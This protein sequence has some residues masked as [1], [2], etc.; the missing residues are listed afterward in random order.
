MGIKKSVI[1]LACGLLS[2]GLLSAQKFGHIDVQKLL[3]VMPEKKNADLEYQKSAQSFQK[4]FD[5]MQT[6]LQGKLAEYQKNASTYSASLRGIKEKE[7]ADMQQRIQTYGATAQQELAKKQQDL[8]SPILDKIKNAIKMVGKEKGF[9][10]V[11]D[12]NAAH[13]MSNES[14]DVLPLVKKKLGIE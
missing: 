2:V 12:I 3:E 14:E 11:F 10:Y 8:L 6:E 1:F 4:E 13:Y 5:A 7:L 9:L